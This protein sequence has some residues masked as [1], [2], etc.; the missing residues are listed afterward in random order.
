MWTRLMRELRHIARFWAV[1]LCGFGQSPLPEPECPLDLETHTAMLIDFCDTHGIRPRAVI[2]HSMG[3]MLA[4]KLAATRP[5]LAERL[6]LM[7]PVVTGRF[8]RWIELNRVVTSDLGQFAMSHGKPVWNLL[9]T[10]AMDL[11]TLPIMMIPWFTQKEVALRIRQDFKRSSWPAASYAINSMAREDMTPY[12][13]QITQPTLV[14]VGSR[15]TT[16]S[17]TEGRFAAHRLPSARLLELPAVS[18]Q[19]LDESPRRVIAAVEDF[20]TAC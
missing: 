15:D 18:H 20:L 5:D 13:D 14:I 2:G 10:N 8:G 7:S 12:L 9:Q 16:V 11:L 4:L 6:V 17:P 3:G 1:D 19:P